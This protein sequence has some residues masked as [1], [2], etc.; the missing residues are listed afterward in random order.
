M[1]KK[2]ISQLVETRLEQGISQTE[3]ARRIGTQRSNICRLESGIQNPSLD[4][5]LKIAS[6]LGKDVS[7]LLEDKEESMNN[8]YS[9]RLYDKDSND[10]RIQIALDE[11]V[12]SKL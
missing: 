8:V 12:E 11:L 4:M 6:A 1:R 9:L 5:I 10:E 3:L 7:L 2:I